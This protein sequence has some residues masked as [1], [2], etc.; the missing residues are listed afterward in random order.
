MIVMP[1]ATFAV[2]FLARQHW[3]VFALETV[4]IF[5][6]AAY[7]LMKTIEFS[8]T[9]GQHRVERLCAAHGD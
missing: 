8:D 2:L 3:S 5:V 6:F 9:E 4:G 1:A 7:W